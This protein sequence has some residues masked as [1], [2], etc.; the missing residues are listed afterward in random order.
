MIRISA[1]IL[2][3][4]ACG[5]AQA[6]QLFDGSGTGAGQSQNEIVILGDG[7]MVMH[8]VGVYEPLATNDPNSPMA[9]LPGK[10]F[11]SIE[12]RGGSATGAG[13]CVFANQEETAVITDWQVTGLAANGALSGQWT[14]VGA[15]G[16]ATGLTGGGSFSN[17]TDRETGTFENT[18]TGALTMP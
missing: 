2:T 7:H 13:H 14:V 9:G 8:S 18:I 10:C 4:F 15:A 3:V 12:I 11:G 16:A 17:L 5:T 6:G 1:V